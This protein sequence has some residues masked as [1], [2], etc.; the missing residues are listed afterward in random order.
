[1]LPKTASGL[2]SALLRLSALNVRFAPESGPKSDIVLCPLGA[3]T[4]REQ[5]QQG[6]P[7]FD[8]LIGAGDECRRHVEAERP[9]GF[10]VD[11]QLE[12]D[13]CLHR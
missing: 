2:E 7:L 1:M 11:R 4:G 10:E 12:F 9:G 6:N 3:I 5:A 8:H 13:W